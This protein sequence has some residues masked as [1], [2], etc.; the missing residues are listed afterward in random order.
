MPVDA[1]IAATNNGQDVRIGIRPE[2]FQPDHGVRIKGRVSFI[3]AQGRETLFNVTL[4]NGDILRSIQG[5]HT[6]A[7]IGDEV[8]WGVQTDHMLI[9]NQDGMR[10]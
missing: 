9:F 10:I 3:E 2:Y 8:A 1:N 7:K 5:S 6:T 4:P